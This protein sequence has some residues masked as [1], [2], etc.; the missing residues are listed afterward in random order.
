MVALGLD[1]FANEN[2]SVVLNLRK[3]MRSKG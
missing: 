1:V 3:D 2:L